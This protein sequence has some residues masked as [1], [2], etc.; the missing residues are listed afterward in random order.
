MVQ[1]G[2][3]V[4][5]SLILSVVLPQHTEGEGEEKLVNESSHRRTQCVGLGVM[6]CEINRGGVRKG[7]GGGGRRVE[8]G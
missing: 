6:W 3:Q 2:N 7:G 5:T 1:R 4:Q 8:I